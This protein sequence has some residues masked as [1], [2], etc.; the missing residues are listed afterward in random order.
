VVTAAIS[1]ACRSPLR[2]ACHGCGPGAPEQRG[3]SLKPVT[4][5]VYRRELRPRAAAG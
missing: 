1:A 4:S 5:P 2:F 3:A